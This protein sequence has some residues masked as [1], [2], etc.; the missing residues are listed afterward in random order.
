[1]SYRRCEHTIWP[2]TQ[3]TTW[4]VSS[5][6]FLF[7]SRVVGK[8]ETKSRLSTSPFSKVPGDWLPVTACHLRGVG[9]GNKPWTWY[10]KRPGLRET[11]LVRWAGPSYFPAATVFWGWR[12]KHLVI[13]R[14]D[15][16]C[17]MDRKGGNFY[18]RHLIKKFWKDLTFPGDKS[19]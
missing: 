2:T 17:L 12:Q 6:G 5:A 19:T 10:L 9:S 7:S 11:S 3:P 14:C 16:F 15:Y 18:S 4:T 1:M 8:G 13:L